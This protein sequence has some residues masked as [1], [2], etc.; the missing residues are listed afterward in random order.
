M[1]KVQRI[2]YIITCVLFIVVLALNPVILI[3]FQDFSTTGILIG[4]IVLYIVSFIALWTKID[5]I[6][7]VLFGVKDFSNNVL[8]TINRAADPRKTKLKNELQETKTLCAMG[9]ALN[10]LI[11]DIGSEFYREFLVQREGDMKMLFAMPNS[12]ALKERSKNESRTAESLSG[13]VEQNLE[14]LERHLSTNNIDVKNVKF[15]TKFYKNYPEINLIITDNYVFCYHYGMSSHGDTV[16]AL[17]IPKGN[18]DK[19]YQ[20]YKKDFFKKIWNDAEQSQVF[21]VTEYFRRESP[22][23]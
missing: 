10:E 2:A 13:W 20:Y 8:I 15:E 12:D 1:K 23:N 6:R 9:I 17:V 14:S 21:L 19:I 7:N 16:P 11:V 4:F 3:F 5:E 22:C 18:N